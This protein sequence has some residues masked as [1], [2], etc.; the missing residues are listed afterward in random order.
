MSSYESE[1][2]NTGPYAYTEA[3]ELHAG[4][5]LVGSMVIL[6]LPFASPLLLYPLSYSES[7]LVEVLTSP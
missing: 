2:T 7:R 6:S 1:P 5:A 4:Q 3:E